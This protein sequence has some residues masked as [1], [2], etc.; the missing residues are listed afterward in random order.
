M[1]KTIAASLSMF[2]TAC[3]AFGQTPVRP[4]AVPLIAN[5]P[6][7]SVWSM[8]DTLNGNPTRHWTGR[9]HRLTS[10]VR[11]DGKS[12][13][14]MGD[15]PSTVT[16]AKQVNL[17]VT[18]TRSIYEFEEG[19]V[20]LT[21]TFMTPMLPDDLMVMSRPVTYVTWSAK[22]TT[23]AS[24]DV[25]VYLDAGAELAVNNADQKVTTQ[26]GSAGAPQ[27]ASCRFRRTAGAGVE[28]G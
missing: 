10:I 18:P 15:Q 25:A 14:L 28:G 21:L 1:N 23:D 24:H 19:G 4:P 9:E 16:A 22:S 7:F 11:I 26:A 17:T 3:S 27:D 8:T 12:F 20:R 2:V 13:R 5:D 6:Y